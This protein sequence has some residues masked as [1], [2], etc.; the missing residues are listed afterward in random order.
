MVKKR[1]YL[2]LILLVFVTSSRLFCMDD[3]RLASE[4]TAKMLS[5]S[6]PIIPVIGGVLALGG[7]ATYLKYHLPR[8]T[9]EENVNRSTRSTTFIQAVENNASKIAMQQDKENSLEKPLL[10]VSDVVKD[11]FSSPRVNPEPGNEEMRESNTTPLSTLSDTGTFLRSHSDNKISNIIDIE[12][13]EKSMFH[14]CPNTPLSFD[15]PSDT[16]SGLILPEQIKAAKEE[17]KNDLEILSES[18]NIL[19]QPVSDSE[20]IAA[21]NRIIGVYRRHLKRKRLAK[22]SIKT[23]NISMNCETLQPNSL[24]AKTDTNLLGSDEEI[25]DSDEENVATNL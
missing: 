18:K 22:K 14:S 17:I 1:N 21:G 2:N 7:A 12:D 3:L 24:E 11:V 15:I 10:R 9:R 23:Q 25:T 19:A 13:S 4:L 20:K 5:G 6:N 16:N 8:S